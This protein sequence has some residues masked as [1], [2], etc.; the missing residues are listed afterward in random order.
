MQ[1]QARSH[2]EFRASL[3]IPAD[4]GIA[5]RVEISAP[6]SAYGE[7]DEKNSFGAGALLVRRTCRGTEHEQQ[8]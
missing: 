6:A 8:L 3:T 4:G 5:S 7:N 1:L 2:G